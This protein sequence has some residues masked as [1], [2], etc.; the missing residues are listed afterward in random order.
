MLWLRDP[1]QVQYSPGQARQAR[2]QH[3][4]K[5]SIFFKW[6]SKLKIVRKVFIS[7][8]CLLFAIIS[9][10]ASPPSFIVWTARSSWAWTSESSF[11]S[12]ALD[13]WGLP[14]KEGMCVLGIERVLECFGALLFKDFKRKWDLPNLPSYPKMPA[15]WVDLSGLWLLPLLILFEIYVSCFF[16]KNAQLLFSLFVQTLTR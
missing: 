11:S 2:L 13:F 16:L 4:D 12:W 6:F 8:P 9:S 1:V 10:S 15:P 5:V 7:E 3:H 14:E